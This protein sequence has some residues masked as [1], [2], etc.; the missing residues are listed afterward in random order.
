MGDLRQIIAI[1]GVSP[2]SAP[3]LFSYVLQQTSAE[4]PRFG[5]LPTASADSD[6]MVAR[7][8]EIVGEFRC[9]PSHL[10]LFGRVSDP[11]EFIRAQDVILVAGGNTKSMLGLWREWGIDALLKD[12]W[13]SGTVLSGFSAGAICWF[14]E[15]FCDSWADQLAPIPALSFLPGSCCPHYD[16]ELDRRPAYQEMVRRGAILP[17]LGIDDDCAVHFRGTAP[18]HVVAARSGASAYSVTKETGSIEEVR[19]DAPTIEL[20]AA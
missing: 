18:Q 17:G 5:Y 11:A 10:S 8:Y 15:A 13:T 12:A 3:L 19:I 9:R 2:P 16:G 1:G 20:P 7:F 4:D 14:E 6:A